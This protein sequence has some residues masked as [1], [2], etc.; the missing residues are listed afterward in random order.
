MKKIILNSLLI[1]ATVFI[2][3]SCKKDYTCTCAV[4]GV[5]VQ[6]A[7]TT[8]KNST[9]KNAQSACDEYGDTH[10]SVNGEMFQLVQVAAMSMW[11][12]MG[13]F[14]SKMFLVVSISINP[15]YI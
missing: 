8:I 10:V 3:S 12:K 15:L 6:G 5:A 7:S 14:L 11:M 9:K 13:M 2:V 1:V 4:Q